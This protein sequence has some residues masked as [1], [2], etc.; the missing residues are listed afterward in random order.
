MTASTEKHTARWGRREHEHAWCPH[1]FA[2]GRPQYSKIQFLEIDFL[3]LQRIT[4]ILTQGRATSQFVTKYYLFHA[5]DRNLFHSYRHGEN[6]E[7]VVRILFV[8]M[9]LFHHFSHPYVLNLMSWLLTWYCTSLLTEKGT[10]EI[11]SRAV[12]HAVISCTALKFE[13][14]SEN[15]KLKTLSTC[16]LK[17]IKNFDFVLKTVNASKSVKLICPFNFNVHSH[18]TS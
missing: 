7:K 10:S 6:N 13:F 2:L 9:V 5:I 4:A 16:S 15:F 18:E 12:S 14:A 17:D 8:M 3:N 11:L 1:E